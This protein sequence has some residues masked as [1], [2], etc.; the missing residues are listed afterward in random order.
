MTNFPIE[1][2]QTKRVRVAICDTQPI[3][4]EGVRVLLESCE[5]F[6]F[7]DWSES[8]EAGTALVRSGHP[9]LIIIDKAFGTH[10]VL[11]WLHI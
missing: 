6:E 8:L 5:D 9:D 11:E 10:A 7:V 1:A 4:A 3:T 2:R